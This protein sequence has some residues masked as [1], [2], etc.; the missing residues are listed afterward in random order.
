MATTDAIR[1][2]NNAL[3]PTAGVAPSNLGRAWEVWRGGSVIEY[4][5][6]LGAAGSLGTGIV[7]NW[8]GTTG[9][10]EVSLPSTLSLSTGGVDD[11]EV[12]IRGQA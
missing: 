2:Q 5:V 1:G 6:T 10:I 9:K 12:R 7:A 3:T 11:C 8:N 4:G